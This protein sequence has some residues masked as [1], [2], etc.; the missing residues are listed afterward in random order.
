MNQIQLQE[1]TSD[2]TDMG[3]ALGSRTS[4]CSSSR[5]GASTRRRTCHPGPDDGSARGT[6]AGMLVVAPVRVKAKG[7]GET[8]EE[9]KRRRRGVGFVVGWEKVDIITNHFKFFIDK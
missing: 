2:G 4:W 6:A 3:S 9:R 5:T 1:S 7:R 8:E